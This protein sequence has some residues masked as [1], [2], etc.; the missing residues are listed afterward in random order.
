MELRNIFNATPQSTWQ[1]FSDVGVGFYI[2]PYQREYN[3]INLILIASLKMLVTGC[4]C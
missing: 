4:N 2:P 1:I 3:W